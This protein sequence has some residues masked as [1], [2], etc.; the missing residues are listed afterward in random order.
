M[1]APPQPP[2]TSPYDIWLLNELWY[3]DTEI[4]DVGVQTFALHRLLLTILCLGWKYVVKSK[5]TIGN[6]IES[7]PAFSAF[8]YLD[9]VFD[10]E[11]DIDP[12]TVAIMK[13]SKSRRGRITS[14]TPYTQG[15]KFNDGVL[16]DCLVQF[17]DGTVEQKVYRIVT[18]SDQEKILHCTIALS[19]LPQGAIPLSN[20]SKKLTLISPNMEPYHDY[21]KKLDADLLVS[22][23]GKR[24][25]ELFDIDTPLYKASTNSRELVGRA[26]LC[27]GGNFLPAIMAS[28]AGI[29]LYTGELLGTRIVDYT[30]QD[31]SRLELTPVKTIK[32]PK[33]VPVTPVSNVNSPMRGISNAPNDQALREIWRADGSVLQEELEQNEEDIAIEEEAIQDWTGEQFELYDDSQVVEDA[34]DGV[35]IQQEA[36]DLAASLEEVVERNGQIEEALIAAEAEKRDLQAKV[37]ALSERLRDSFAVKDQLQAQVNGYG[38]AAVDYKEKLTVSEAERG[39]LNQALASTQ[40]ELAQTGAQLRADIVALQTRLQEVGNEAALRFQIETRLKEV[41]AEFEAYIAERTAVVEKLQQVLQS[42]EAELAGMST[43]VKELE[44]VETRYT[45]IMRALEEQVEEMRQ[46]AVAT[47][48]ELQ[49]KELASQKLQ[50]QLDQSKI[51]LTQLT[52][53]LEAKTAELNNLSDTLLAQKN[54][55]AAASTKSAADALAAKTEIATLQTEVQHQKNLFAEQQK[56]TEAVMKEYERVEDEKLALKQAMVEKTREWEAITA[57]LRSVGTVETTKAAEML[58]K[59]T[60]GDKMI[61][62]LQTKLTAAEAERDAYLQSGKKTAQT[63]AQKVSELEKLQATYNKT[64]KQVSQ[65]DAQRATAV[66]L[67]TEVKGFKSAISIKDQEIAT[68]K[69][70]I[71]T[72]RKTQARESA[73]DVASVSNIEA[74]EEL[75]QLRKQYEEEKLILQFEVE[76]AKEEGQ[77]LAATLSELEAA[78]AKTEANFEK[79]KEAL[80]E[81]QQQ[82]SQ[83]AVQDSVALSAAAEKEKADLKLR[84][85]TL[86]SEYSAL[87]QQA[88]SRADPTVVAQLEQRLTATLKE[89]HQTRSS[90]STV[91]K[92]QIL[93]NT[94]DYLKI[95][96]LRVRTS[97]ENAELSGVK[98]YKWLTP[99]LL[100]EQGMS[101]A[102]ATHL[103]Q[104]VQ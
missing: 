83:V 90:L 80:S 27:V 54:E 64:A 41:E 77:K 82:A 103:L 71:D 33:T 9:V 55:F 18:W 101:S 37:Q 43:R 75:A 94:A 47:G 104:A 66:R 74:Q 59:L 29:K 50:T 57:E 62:S 51:Q 23:Q 22:Y 15:A 78:K 73:S 21:S 93:Q 65:L 60:E 89:L 76:F 28:V 31:F 98:G 46:A 3:I 30:Y 91:L 35:L 39:Q 70:E 88:Q 45:N 12:P 69:S 26:S 13:D 1:A 19:E 84:I 8:Q 44:L 34:T 97:Q 61:Q 10:N 48:V 52:T 7:D 20:A 42:K 56:A 5:P 36:I 85:Q 68:L 96:S 81:L 2:L 100:R 53:R 58:T 4:K 40:N 17:N 86:E 49:A 67:S 25:A 24:L 14:A 63:L 102:F 38:R 16:Y 95:D 92:L 32:T 79:M 11:L 72:L 99:Q 87:S 6:N